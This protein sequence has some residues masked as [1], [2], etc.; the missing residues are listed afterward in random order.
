MTNYT[1]AQFKGRGKNIAADDAQASAQASALGLNAGERDW[2]DEQIEAVVRHVAGQAAAAGHCGF[3]L[4]CPA[5]DVR[6]RMRTLLLEELQGKWSEVSY[7]RACAMDVS[8]TWD[9]VLHNSSI[10]RVSA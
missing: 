10:V 8:D 7:V 5:A 6:K 2:T 1:T 4:D 3:H 9:L